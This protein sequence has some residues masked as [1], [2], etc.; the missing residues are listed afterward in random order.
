M[1]LKQE[2]L[3]GS[4]LVVGVGLGDGTASALPHMPGNS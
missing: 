4:G 3:A 1:T 2:G